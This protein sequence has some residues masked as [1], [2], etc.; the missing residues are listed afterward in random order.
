MSMCVKYGCDFQ[1]DLDGQV[2]CVACGAMDDDKQH[3]W[4]EKPNIKNI[5][6]E[7][8]VNFE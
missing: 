3:A 6:F 8:Q 2:T 5:L 7:S 4:E 1:L